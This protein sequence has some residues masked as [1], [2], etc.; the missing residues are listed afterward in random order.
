M[1]R[2]KSVVAGVAF[3]SALTMLGSTVLATTAQAQGATPGVT[4]NTI[5]VG[6]P[7]VDL[8]S[9]AQ[10]TNG[11]NQGSY[12]G[13][14]GALINA[15]NKAGGIDGRKLKADYVAV[16]PIGTD[17]STAACN[18]LT[19]DDQVFAVMGFFQNNDV[20]CYTQL[21]DTPV[22]GGTVTTQLLKGDKAPWF[23][24]GPIDNVIEPAV[25]TAA[26]KAGVFKGKK[27]A[28]I[29]LSNEASGLTNSVLNA[30]KSNGVKPVAVATV[31]ANTSD[32]EASLQQIN[33]VVALKFKAAGAN[34]VI[35]VGQA[36]QTWGNATVSG[37]YHPEVVAPSYVAFSAYTGG[38]A[39]SP[40]VLTNA[41]SGALEPLSVGST[42]KGWSDPALQKCV[43][44]VKA[45][46]QKITPPMTA[47]SPDNT[48]VSVLQACQ[49]LALFEAIAKRAGKDLTVAS[50][51]KAGNTLGSVHIPGQ[52]DGSYSKTQP[53]GS[54]PLYVYRWSTAQSAW[55]P[56]SQAYGTSGG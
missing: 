18:Q 32:P 12:S 5:T 1:L 21:H 6:V 44:T 49:Y 33:N 43:N 41:V 40:A 54:F 23:G 46:G 17:S 48:Y 29:S 15:I 36:S 30:L 25:I 4:S 39:A 55:V 11:L 42:P 8:A 9:V 50:F 34:I 22:I 14:Y 51:E 38:S 35:P 47:K 27:V 45:S 52:G 10:F 2:R 19:Q 56:S 53:A 7:Y 28:V 26:A 31:I 37:S 20:A 3:A 13:A 16:N 24:T